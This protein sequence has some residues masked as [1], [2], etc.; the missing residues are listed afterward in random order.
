MQKKPSISQVS[1][2]REK[3]LKY[4]RY[5]LNKSWKPG[6][7]L[8]SISQL[9]KAARVSIVP[10]WKAVNQLASE[11]VLEVIQGSGTRVSIS[12]EEPVNA[13]RKGWLGLRDRIHKDILTGLYPSGTLM[14]S[15][16]EV[17]AYYGV[18]HQTL[19]KALDS[20]VVEGVIQP[21]HRTYKV[22][23]FSPS[24]A[25][26]S[27]VLLG[28]SDPTI[29]LQSRTPWGEEFLRICENLCSQMKVRLQIIRYTRLDGR[30]V[31]TN[32]N[33]TTFDRLRSDDSVLGYLLWA[34]SPGELYREVLSQIDLFQKPI[35]VLQEGTRLQLGSSSGRNRGLK[36]FSIATGSNAARSLASY[37]LQQGHSKAA[38]ISPFHKSDWSRARLYGLQEIFQRQGN[39]A[40]IQPFTLNEY[41]YSHEFRLSLKSSEILFQDLMKPRNANGI[42]KRAALRIRPS[43][44]RIIDDEA[45]RAFLNPLFVKAASDAYC[46]A[47]VCANDRVAFMALDYLKEHVSRRIAV[48]AFD[49]T[50]EAFRRGLTSYNFNIHGL[51]QLMLS[52]LLNPSSHKSR[53]NNT[54]EIEGVLVVRNTTFSNVG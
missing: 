8:P 43:L 48:A 6:D 22:I 54:V 25:H 29:E 41:R 49:D 24:K 14:P 26:S 33:G 13:L 46:S 40:V 10:M 5:M 38:Y 44:S 47:W 18:S 20:L 31:F 12:F 39:G 3:A 11:G 32:Q 35:A 27:I 30:V 16:K 42:L 15:L 37:L 53:E 23:S 50:F 28:W 34:E 7:P 36:I 2:A 52:H 51:V 1:P 21:E 45:V 9:A 19:R 17:K 4:L